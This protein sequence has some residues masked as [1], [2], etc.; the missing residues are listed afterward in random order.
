LYRPQ[1]VTNF[2][3]M[4]KNKPV[5]AVLLE[6]VAEVMGLDGQVRLELAY[7]DGELIQWWSH[8]ERRRV[9]ELG[10]FDERAA[11]LTRD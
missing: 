5:L 7:R 3:Q 8:H 10:R 9:A 2:L 4:G 11:F 1:F 6:R